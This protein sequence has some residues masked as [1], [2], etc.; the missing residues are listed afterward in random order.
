MAQHHKSRIIVM[1]SGG[2]VAGVISLSDI[3][4]NVDAFHAAQTM[5]QV[6]SEKPGRCRRP[7]R[8]QREF[9]PYIGQVP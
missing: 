4:E 3:A 6:P 7:E 8:A 5:K 1:E 2:R 9:D